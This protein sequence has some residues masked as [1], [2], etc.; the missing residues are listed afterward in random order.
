MA[1]QTGK[2]T[3]E[4]Q[5]QEF[6]NAMENIELIATGFPMVLSWLLRS[7][8]YA[9]GVPDKKPLDLFT[10]LLLLVHKS[11]A[12]NLHLLITKSILRI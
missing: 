12:T 6:L 2:P 1:F 7:E 4:G 8:E 9:E 5:E 11:Q 3:T 10:F